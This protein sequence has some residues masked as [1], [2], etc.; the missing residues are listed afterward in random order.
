MIT[1]RTTLSADILARPD[2]IIQGEFCRDM[3]P[4]RGSGLIDPGDWPGGYF[5]AVVAMAL[6]TRTPA[7]RAMLDQAEALFVRALDSDRESMRVYGT[8]GSKADPG[9][10][11]ACPRGLACLAALLNSLS[12]AISLRETL[13]T[14]DV[15]FQDVDIPLRR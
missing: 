7:E 5:A 1:I 3:G 8:N 15:D 12:Q 14:I 9:R 6:R 11:S 10:A 13:N 4:P 2:H